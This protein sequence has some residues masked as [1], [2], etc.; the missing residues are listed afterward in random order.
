MQSSMLTILGS[1]TQQD[2]L[3]PLVILLLMLYYYK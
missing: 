2:V 1:L 3:V